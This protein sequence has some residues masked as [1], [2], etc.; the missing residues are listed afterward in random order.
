VLNWLLRQPAAPLYLTGDSGTGKSSLLQ[1]FVLPALC[2]A[3]WTA[4][5]V[6]TLDDPEAALRRSLGGTY[7]NS[8][9]TRALLARAAR[10]SKG[11]L[12]VVLDQFEEF[13]ILQND[14]QTTTAEGFRRLLDQ[15][16]TEPVLG[17]RLLLVLRSDYQPL[18]ERLGLPP[19]RQ[20]RTGGK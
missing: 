15:L 16:A 4:K 8:T 10:K 12:L 9:N 11:N 18:V 20:G 19:L 17:V 1:A 13:V 7:G 3:G 2:E 6:R 14:A 5:V